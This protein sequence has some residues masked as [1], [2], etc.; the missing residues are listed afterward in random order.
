MFFSKPGPTRQIILNQV[1]EERIV[2][3]GLASGVLG[4]KKQSESAKQHGRRSASSTE[5]LLDRSPR[6]GRAREAVGAEPRFGRHTQGVEE[7]RPKLLGRNRAITDV[8]ALRIRSAVHQAAAD[9][10]ARQTSRAA[11]RPMVAP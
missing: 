11:G 10:G 4:S 7:G 5:E 6:A 8:T 2:I 9:A 3:H 1:I